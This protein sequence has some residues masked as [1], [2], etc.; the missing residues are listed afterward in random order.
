MPLSKLAAPPDAGPRGGRA[1]VGVYAGCAG[2]AATGGP[3]PR[4]QRGRFLADDNTGVDL[5]A[6]I[7]GLTAPAAA[8]AAAWAGV[9][10]HGTFA[11]ASTVWGPVVSHASAD[12]PPHVALTFDGGPGLDSAEGLL[13]ELG[14]LGVPAAFFVA[15][16][17]AERSPDLLGRLDAAGHLIGN[18]AWDRHPLGLLRD[19][20]Y[21]SALIR[22]TD[23]AIERAIGRRPALL[24]PWAGVKTCHM[25]SAAGRTGHAVVTWS[26][27]ASDGAAATFV[28]GDVIR[29]GMGAGAVSAVRS[30][31]R[32]LHEHGLS[33]RR[34]D[35]LLGIPAYRDPRN[36]QSESQRRPAPLRRAA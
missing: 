19:R 32:S 15:G 21:W 27:R 10:A 18:L 26:R 36:V 31:L 14:D 8:C 3:G 2:P 12:G 34:L 7:T 20:S 13:D 28:R 5:L 25:M 1:G 22:R 24:R 17:D 35:A 16:R 4:R 29:I 23:A 6:D 11:A 30:L 9:F 33:P